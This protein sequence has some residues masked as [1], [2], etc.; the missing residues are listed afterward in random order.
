[1]GA[2]TTSPVPDGYYPYSLEVVQR[3]EKYIGTAYE[4]MTCSQLTAEAYGAL[5]PE[6]TGTAEKQWR[7]VQDSPDWKY[8]E[9]TNPDRLEDSGIAYGDLLF[10]ACPDCQCNGE[11]KGCKRSNIHHVAIYLGNNWMLDSG[12]NGVSKRLVDDI[13]PDSHGDYIPCGYARP[14]VG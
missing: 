8:Q 1:M 3:A 9:I 2:P 13:Q 4:K 6:I 14:S 12:R 10:F 5:F 11:S 7:N